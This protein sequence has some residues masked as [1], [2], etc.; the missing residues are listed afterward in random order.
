MGSLN[1]QYNIKV[2]VNCVTV[3]ITNLIPLQIDSY[4]YKW[5]SQFEIFTIILF[6]LKFE[7][8][9]T[10]LEII[11][12]L[13]FSTAA[14]SLKYRRLYGLVVISNLIGFNN[15]CLGSSFTRE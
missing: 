10:P 4:E 14:S 11:I 12:D 15:M 2:Y 7:S 9:Y 3:R 1:T 5:L 13:R 6:Y 8:L